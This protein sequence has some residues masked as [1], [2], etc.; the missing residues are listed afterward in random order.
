MSKIATIILAAGKGTRMPSKRPKALYEIAGMPMIAHV[1]SEVC[2]LGNITPH[3]VVGY[4]AQQVK[5]AFTLDTA[6]WHTQDPQLG[7]AHAVACALDHIKDDDTVLVTYT[8]MPLLKSSV[9]QEMLDKTNDQNFVVLTTH[10]PDPHGYGRIVRND[11]HQA[12]A[13]VEEADANAEQKQINEVNVGV[14]TAK[15]KT[16]KALIQ[17]VSN[18]NKPQE[19][20]LTDCLGIASDK[21]VPVVCV[22]LQDP[23]QARGVNS[24]IE[25]QHAERILQKQIATT[26]A[27]RASVKDINRIDIRGEV[28][29]GTDISFDIG[30]ILEGKVVIGSGTKIGPYTVIKNAVIG[31]NSHIKAFSHIEDSK[32]GNHCS[33]GPYARLRPET[34]IDDGAQIGN[35][36]EIKKSHIGTQTKIN[37]LSYIGDSEVGKDTNIGAGTI[38][39]NYDGANKHKTIIEDGVFIGSDTQIIA[40]VTIG[41]GATIGAGSTITHDAQANALTLSRSEQKTVKGWKRPQKNPPKDKQ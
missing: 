30:V 8:D 20:Y 36:V 37:H 23:Q 13:I 27:K 12:I 10:L 39:C 9:Y 26:L 4:R 21:G 17:E 33:I 2:A 7:T 14:V 24:G 31:S 11:N 5:D 19:Y 1:L 29:V 34:V 3:I 35:F 25:A 18:D 28:Q 41:K 32:I 40:P 6:Q 16:L 15:A 38:T 22:V